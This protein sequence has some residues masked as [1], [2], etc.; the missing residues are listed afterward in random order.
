MKA[1]RDYTIT[2]VKKALEILKLFNDQHT[3]LTLSE[4]GRAHV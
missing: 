2:S 4:I 3:S 1:T